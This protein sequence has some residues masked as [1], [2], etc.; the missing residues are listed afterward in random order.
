MKDLPLQNIPEL[1]KEAVKRASD[2][3]VELVLE[4][5]EKDY[6]MYENKGSG[7]KYLIQ[8][9]QKFDLFGFMSFKDDFPEASLYIYIGPQFLFI[10]LGDK[11]R[12]A[13]TNKSDWDCTKFKELNQEHQWCSALILFQRI[14][15]IIF[16]YKSWTLIDKDMAK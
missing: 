1:I 12:I 10:Y 5:E 8:T 3:E 11:F 13:Y 6:W 2:V 7:N 15:G 9:S 14:G 4:K 16:D